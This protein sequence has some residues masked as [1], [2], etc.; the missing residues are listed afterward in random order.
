MCSDLVWDYECVG[1][2]SSSGRSIAD[3][4][5]RWWSWWTR[6]M[7]YLRR[8]THTPPPPCF[9]LHVTWQYVGHVRRILISLGRR[10]W[11]HWAD[12]QIRLT[13]FSKCSTGEEREEG[14][15]GNIMAA[16]W[17]LIRSLI[18]MGNASGKKCCCCA[19]VHAVCGK[20]RGNNKQTEA[21]AVEVAAA[22]VATKAGAA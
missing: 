9:S 15:E 12:K 8:Q 11:S 19:C 14:G 21:V 6:R 17:Q 7:S 13:L 10:V 1:C 3:R 16:L 4:S 22:V 2:S 20:R 18:C 5:Q